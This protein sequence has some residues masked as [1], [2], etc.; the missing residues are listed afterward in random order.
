[1]KIYE[2]HHKI[3]DIVL[4]GIL[5]LIKAL[6]T[7]YSH[8][9]QG[10]LD[11]LIRYLIH[12]CLFEIPSKH[13]NQK[14]VSPKCKSEGNRNAAFDLLFSLCHDSEKNMALVYEY[15]MGL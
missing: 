9:N 11:K 4:H 1:M 5:T 15:L 14:T 6:F 7:R 8:K 12:D 2:K 3:F 10:V 13:D